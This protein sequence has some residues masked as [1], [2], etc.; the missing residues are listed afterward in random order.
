MFTS[1]L[2]RLKRIL[3][4][5]EP[6]AICAGLPRWVPKGL[7]R[8][9]RLAPDRAWFDLTAKGYDRKMLARLKT[10]DPRALYAELGENAVLL[11]WEAPGVRCHR[12]M[13]AEWFEQAL[14]IEVP[15]LGFARAE[16]GAYSELRR[17]S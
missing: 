1:N 2:A 14:G 5:L 4:P 8:E 16:Y 13:V 6:I 12:R 17:K 9:L 3:P 15:E 11:C 10:L 7:R